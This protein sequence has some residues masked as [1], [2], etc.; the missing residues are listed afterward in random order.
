[1]F[2]EGQRWI[3]ETEPELGLGTV[4]QVATGRVQVLFTTSGEMRMY[5]ADHAP[6]K[7]VQFRAGD[8]ISTHE[9]DQLTVQSVRETEGLLTYVCGGREVP[10]AL[11]SDTISFQTARDRLLN[12]HID[13]L[14]DYQ[15]RTRTLDFQHHRRKSAVRGFV[16]GRI[17]LIP[18]QLYIAHEVSSRQAPRVLLSDEVGLG[19]TIEACLILHRMLLT[20]RASRILIVVPDSLVHQWFIEMLRRFNIWMHIFDE[21]RCAAVESGA[22]DGN[23]FLDDQLIL[24]SLQF[25]ASSPRRSAQALSAGWDMLVVDEAHHLEWSPE[26]SSPEY[27]LIEALGRKAEGL[28]LLTATPEQLG[29]ES[30]FA[31]LRLLDPD[32]YTDYASFTTEPHQYKTTAD[33]IAR[34]TAKQQLTPQNQADLKELFSHDAD[35]LAN[36]LTAI[37]EG[38]DTKRKALINDMLDLH[39]PGRVIFRN[40]RSAMTDF[41][42]RIV[43]L[44]P[45][46]TK[47]QNLIAK[48]ADEF[49]T[50]A[51]AASPEESEPIRFGRD[52]RLDWLIGLLKTLETEKVLLICRSMEKALALHETLRQRI[53][54]KAAVFHE[55]LSLVQRDRNAAWFAEVDGARLLICSEIGSE[56]R[57]FQFAHH[58]VLF[59]LPLNPELLEQ[60]IGRLDRIGQTETINIH[61]PYVLGTPQEVLSNWYHAGLDAFESSLEGGNALLQQFGEAVFDLAMASPRMMPREKSQAQQS[62]IEETRTARKALQEKLEHGRDRL[63][64]LNSFR[65]DTAH[66][67]IAAIRREDDNPRMKQYMLDVF[68]YFDIACDELSAGIFRLRTQPT[69][70]ASFSSIP[71]EGMMITFD[72]ALAL[73]REDI[74]FLSIDH[75]LVTEAIDLVYGSEKGNSSFA[76]WPDPENQALLLELRFVLETVADRQLH[77]DR[78]LPATPIR[79]LIDQALDDQSGDI[80]ADRLATFLRKGNPEALLSQPIITQEHLPNMIDAATVKAEAKA[81]LIMSR[82]MHA[83]HQLMDHEIDRLRM[84]QQVNDNVRKEEISQTIREKEALTEAIQQAR[85]RLDAMQLIWKGP[86]I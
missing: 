34:L 14:V 16:G 65:P 40:T 50:D 13:S 49:A 17:D 71:E 8:T 27:A 24:C 60:R 70:K 20:G 22:P 12:G 35:R 11:L 67:L 4:V 47:N 72:R 3:S 77:V 63:L 48:L 6:L 25:L 80:T 21:E 68:E 76:L 37:D 10:E 39:G 58:L 30:H 36:R 66:Q 83:M 82:S 19:K 64:E 38:D 42:K 61:V 29:A 44:A 41:P 7:R 56:G 84:L 1:M 74:T 2:V 51:Q 78:F 32:R 79:I 52:V 62:L 18:H 53:N 57:N 15:I 54:L 26:G 45:L 9:G 43:H 23:P 85:L 86:T 46:S 31:R 33:L 75:P 69:T 5:A 81:A 59:D 73:S 28:L 55:D